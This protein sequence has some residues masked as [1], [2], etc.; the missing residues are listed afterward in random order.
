MPETTRVERPWIP[1]H[2]CPWLAA[3]VV[4]WLILP[5]HAT[6]QAP[7][8]PPRDGTLMA[9]ART[10]QTDVNYDRLAIPEKLPILV[11]GQN[12][13]VING[14][15]SQSS[16]FG[17]AFEVPTPFAASTLDFRVKA[18]VG[19]EIHA[20]LV[21]WGAHPQ[22]GAATYCSANSRPEPFRE[23][24][25]YQ[26]DTLSGVQLTANEVQIL[27]NAAN[28]PYECIFHQQPHPPQS[29]G[30]AQVSSMAVVV[31]IDVDDPTALPSAAITLEFEL[32]GAPLARQTVVAFSH[33]RAVPM[34]TAKTQRAAGISGVGTDL[35]T[36]DATYG[37]QLF[38]AKGP[39][40]PLDMSLSYHSSNSQ[41]WNAVGRSLQRA[42]TSY[43]P[44]GH[45]WSNLY[46]LRLFE[47]S[48]SS[49][50]RFKNHPALF[51]QDANGR[52]VQFRESVNPNVYVSSSAVTWTEGISP[53]FGEQYRYLVIEYLPA[54][55]EFLMY[56]NVSPLIARFDR[57][58]RLTELKSRQHARPLTLA[59]PSD[60]VVITDSSDRSMTWHL[61][62]QNL[63]ER[64]DGPGNRIWHFAYSGHSLMQVSQGGLGWGFDYDPKTLAMRYMT[65]PG[66]RLEVTLD[67]APMGNPNRWAHR[68]LES[69]TEA[70]S[71]GGGT[72]SL[73]RYPA[74][75]IG[76]YGPLDQEFVQSFDVAAS[77]AGIDATYEMR[78]LYNAGSYWNMTRRQGGHREFFEF[79]RDFQNIRST[80]AK[81]R[82]T[83]YER[84]TL[85]TNSQNAVL[86]PY[87]RLL[88]INYP[89]QTQEVYAAYGGPQH[90]ARVLA[91]LD[92][93]GARTD[94]D[95]IDG[96]GFQDLVQRIT[97][98]RAYPSEPNRPQRLYTYNADG[99]LTST[100]DP[101]GRTTHYEPSTTPGR[102]GLVEAVRQGGGS[103]AP[104]TVFTYDDLGSVTSTTQPEGDVTTYTYDPWGRIATT[105]PAKGGTITYTYDPNGRVGSI[106]ADWGPTI[107]YTYDDFGRLESLGRT[108]YG[109]TF[110]TYHPDH[111]LATV[112]DPRGNTSQFDYDGRGFL[113]N[114]RLPTGIPSQPF[115]NRTFRY[116]EVGSLRQI[117][118]GSRITDFYYDDMERPYHIDLPETA[119]PMGHIWRPSR[120]IDYVP[121]TELPMEIRQYVAPN[122]TERMGYLY[123]DRDQ[124]VAQWRGI[125]GTA[126]YLESF[127]DYDLAGRLTGISG[128]CNP[129]Q[130]LPA[131]RSETTS[132]LQYDNLGRPVAITDSQ[133]RIVY[134][135]DRDG[136][137]RVVRVETP[138]AKGQLVVTRTQTFDVVTGRLLA[139]TVPGRGTTSFVH[140]S[141]GR[142]IRTTDPLGNTLVTSFDSAGR[143]E[144]WGRTGVGANGSTSQEQSWVAYSPVGDV[145]E[146][147]QWMGSSQPHVTSHQYDGLGRKVATSD[148]YKRTFRRTFDSDG[149]V[150]SVTQPSGLTS[151]FDYD[152]WGRLLRAEHGLGSNHQNVVYTHFDLMGRLMRAEDAMATVEYQRD[153]LGRIAEESVAS[154]AGYLA[155]TA[156]YAYDACG[157]LASM[158]NSQGELLEY[159]YTTENQLAEVLF[160]GQSHGRFTYDVAG[161]RTSEQLGPHLL[162][163]GWNAVGDL[164]SI[165][166]PPPQN[167]GGLALTY[168]YDALGRRI[169][170]QDA[171]H[172]IDR[173]WVR[174]GLGRLAE[175]RFEHQGSPLYRDLRTYDEAGNLIYRNENGSPSQYSH[176]LFNQLQ[177]ATHWQRTPIGGLSAT[178]DSAPPD[179]NQGAASVV[180]G[181]AGTLYVGPN[182]DSAPRWLE[183]QLPGPQAVSGLEVDFAAGNR[184]PRE[185][186]LQYLDGSGSWADF[187]AVAL[188]GGTQDGRHWTPGQPLPISPEGS[189]LVALFEADTTGQGPH[190]VV[191]TDRLRILQPI[192]G[193]AASGAAYAAG[194]N[195][196]GQERA[197]TIDEVRVSSVA[198]SAT[199]TSYQYRDGNLTHDGQRHFE[200]DVQNRLVRITGGGA[201]ATYEHDPL[202]RLMAEIDHDTGASRQHT[203]L[204]K[205]IF[206]TFDENGSLLSQYLHGAGIDRK[207]GV[208]SHENGGPEPY[209]FLRDGQNTTRQVIDPAGQPIDNRLM[210]AWGHPLEIPGFTPEADYASAVGYTGRR[211]LLGGGGLMN[212]RARVYDRDAGRFL[213]TDPGGTRDGLNRY[214]Y[215]GGDPVQTFDPSGMDGEESDGLVVLYLQHMGIMAPD[216][217]VIKKA[218]TG[219]PGEVADAFSM[220]LGDLMSVT[221]HGKLMS[222]MELSDAFWERWLPTPTAKAE[223]TADI[224]NETIGSA[225]LARA[226][227]ATGNDP[228]VALCWA[229][230][231][232]TKIS[233]FM[234][235]GPSA[236]ARGGAARGGRFVMIAVR[237]QVK[238]NR[239]WRALSQ[240]QSKINPTK[241]PFSVLSWLESFTGP[242]PR[243]QLLS[244]HE[245]TAKSLPRRN[246]DFRLAPTETPTLVTNGRIKVDHVRGYAR[247]AI[248][249]DQEVVLLTGAHGTPRGNL[250]PE[251]D[252]LMHDEVYYGTEL[253]IE[254]VDITN[255]SLDRL[256]QILT[257]DK[258]VIANWCYSSVTIKMLHDALGIR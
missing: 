196:P 162:T 118:D 131:G 21:I 236:A 60:R 237:D 199:V 142:R 68:L 144:R 133:Q 99:D 1:P 103:A 119:D 20:S 247:E 255:V 155:T 170:E 177:D 7:V 113:S 19:V 92:R 239:L 156:T 25:R 12:L 67:Y 176:D 203:Y 214:T 17:L 242:R 63:V 29:F 38:G 183:I 202:G 230:V 179:P 126:E 241:Q 216:P 31:Y 243:R 153:H 107:S 127:L 94:Y 135:V 91:T 181:T 249:R 42:L 8:D 163:Y 88:R 209:Y 151:H 253:G 35:L 148:P 229:R 184:P 227:D 191:Q 254:V 154:T 224:V 128:A 215:V 252:F 185:V 228:F 234:F 160:E 195:P 188:T 80:D 109:T 200:Y 140:D 129:N 159:R 248:E 11:D 136:N 122:R 13:G 157:L 18:P 178:A 15:Q 112:T 205:E 93:K 39:G 238:A 106:H 104:R 235:M 165:Q 257:G 120:Q 41:V 226:I 9:G 81:G 89:D 72:A 101:T 225:D 211:T 141:Y 55:Q 3:L 47:V 111:R 256:R 244:R 207:L 168:D 220:M 75:R 150:A 64:V 95:F 16:T 221:P 143:P 32:N 33:H 190:P 2:F 125:P 208:L 149:N 114:E 90:P 217:E 171:I 61:D 51:F 74:T 206:E 10:I 146:V 198:A 152:T 232:L 240:N 40:L 57:G 85:G 245:W 70:S 145:V 192:A 46:T 30:L 201:D 251:P 102:R 115:R 233:G 23:P 258:C 45:G 100:T 189:Q 105:H 246:G 134:R 132:T 34:G 53:A 49:E 84:E 169:R 139:V 71:Q 213:S 87:D 73:Y 137:G 167:S 65:P 98:P 14:F 173:H 186:R 218:M 180:D 175:E 222:G 6:A 56:A 54:S 62:A 116:N 164:L 166:S 24:G 123:D 66:G 147:S 96:N 138:D 27:P 212:Y 197:L 78:T 59:Y 124:T 69:F 43:T 223:E 193:G 44:F 174:D 121:G 36:G 182:D 28:T 110:Y 158:Q 194:D 204:G 86:G 250:V 48:E 172:G 97:Y 52:L 161:R 37:M 58:G 4:L 108:G 77:E 22:P 82:V 26:I 76:G 50:R 210:N 5:P 117:E 130:P 231:G 83:E 187:R 79:D 219:G